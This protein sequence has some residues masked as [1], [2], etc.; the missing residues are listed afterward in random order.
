MS[1]ALV[2]V[3]LLVVA[4]LA[5]ARPPTRRDTG[6]REGWG[7]GRRGGPGDWAR[8]DSPYAACA[9][10]TRQSPVDIR[11]TVK[12]VLPRLELQY[13]ATPLQLAHDGHTVQVNVPPGSILTVDGRVHEL[14]QF[15][16]HT[17]SEESVRGRRSPLAAHLV[18]RGADG[19]LAVVAVLFEVGKPNRGLAQIFGRLPR[20]PGEARSYRQASLN[21]AAILPGA[22]GY[23]SFEGSLTTPPCTEGVS[24]FVLRTA[25]TISRRQLAAY[26]KLYGDN[27]RPLQRLNGRVVRESS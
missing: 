6:A 21:P 16:F 15:H 3:V 10:G 5:G 17:P 11:T 20:E 24:W 26:R 12:S 22:L 1:R 7:Y 19:R 4:G 8:L 13:R 25:A 27:A 23:F 2:A 14:L 9:E 18:H